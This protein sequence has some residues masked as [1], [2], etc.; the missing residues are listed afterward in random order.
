MAEIQKEVTPAQKGVG[1]AVADLFQNERMANPPK[2][3]A[4]S[5]KDANSIVPPYVH[6]DTPA[7]VENA[8]RNS[9]PRWKPAETAPKD[10]ATT[11]KELSINLKDTQDGL[12]EY[13]AKSDP[14][15]YDLEV[16]RRGLL[17]NP[18]KILTAGSGLALLNA[19]PKLSALQVTGVAALQGYD[20]YK[21]LLDS[22]TLGGRSKYALGLVADASIAAGSV[23]FL[24]ESVPMKYKAPM[25]FGGLAVRAALD[26]IPTKK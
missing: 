16:S 7:G 2:S 10:L 24:L 15:L 20:D 4:D 23:S 17:T 9:Q 3:G 6:A 8:E 21:N 19:S 18:Y 13:L 25:L 5:I 12:K 14:S 22:K 1:A 11:L 26:F